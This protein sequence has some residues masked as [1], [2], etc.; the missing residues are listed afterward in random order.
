MIPKETIDKIFEEREGSDYEVFE[1]EMTPIKTALDPKN[2]FMLAGEPNFK[3]SHDIIRKLRVG[4]FSTNNWYYDVIT[5]KVHFNNFR[6]NENVKKAND[7]EVSPSDYKNPPSRIILGALDTGTTSV[8]ADGKGTDAPQDQ[9]RLQAQSA[10]RYSALFSQSLDIAVP[11]NL[12]LRAGLLV[13]VNFPNLNTDR[14]IP[15]NSPE[16]GI[17]MI[18]R[19]SHE[20]GNPTGDFTGLTLVRDSFTI[21]E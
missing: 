14:S 10:A 6:Y 7:E 8:N 9:A 15:K 3:E 18:A 11:M 21:E 1:Y 12:T 2:N 20:L 5:R 16:S 4:S 19:L 17:Y 13:K